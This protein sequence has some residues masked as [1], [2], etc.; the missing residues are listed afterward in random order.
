MGKRILITGASGM[1]GGLVLK[2]AIE[3][4]QTEEVI[5][6][7][8]E[9]SGKTEPK[10]KEIVVE[11]F[12]DY[13]VV[14]DSFK[15]VDAAFFCIGVYAGSVSDEAFKKVTFD[16]AVNFAKTLK[17][18]SPSSTLCLLSGGGADRTGKSRFSF[19]KYKGMAEERISQMGLKFYVFRP[20]YIY[21]VTPRK[22]PDFSYRM[23]RFMYPVIKRLGAKISIKSTE[24]AAAM[25]K[26]GISGADKEILENAD[27]LHLIKSN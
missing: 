17:E 24:L 5:S 2:N 7:V 21:P 11:D 20:G 14:S 3:S 12:A 10:V 6:L 1:T 18:N 26:A 15:N 16:F 8:R 25:F 19:A 27:I 23:L 4:N 22:E 13:S 9:I